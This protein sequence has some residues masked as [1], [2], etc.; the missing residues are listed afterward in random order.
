MFH[1]HYFK[2]LQKTEFRLIQEAG[3]LRKQA[4]GMPHGMRRDELLRKAG[5]MDVAS[6]INNWASSSGLRT[7]T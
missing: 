4:E 7:P 3:N 6:Q 1:R 5:Q 2:Q